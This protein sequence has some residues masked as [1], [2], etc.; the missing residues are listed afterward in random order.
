MGSAAVSLQWGLEWTFT[1]HTAFPSPLKIQPGHWRPR[2]IYPTAARAQASIQPFWVCY[3]SR[4]SSSSKRQ[5]LP[6][7]LLGYFVNPWVL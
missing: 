7:Y 2:R 6:C 1:K 4:E 5:I 3:H